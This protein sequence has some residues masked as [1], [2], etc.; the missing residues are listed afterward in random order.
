[1]DYLEAGVGQQQGIGI[2]QADVLGG[3]DA[4]AACDEK[5]V[6]TAVQHACKPIDGRIRVGTAHGL[7]ECGDDVVVHLTALV[8]DG[9]V[10]LQA[11]RNRLI[12]NDNGLVRQMGV[13]YYLQYVQQFPGISAA[14]PEKGFG[15][16]DLDVAL[17]Q[18]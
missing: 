4:Q 7:D 3:Q 6:L 17:P 8:V 9:D 11:F 5:R 13:H 1:M 12:V 16:I 14:V 18:E 15:L 2:G 10:L